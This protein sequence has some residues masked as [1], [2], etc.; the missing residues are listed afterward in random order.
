MAERFG[1]RFSPDNARPPEDG[2]APP[3]APGPLAGQRPR[4]AGARI[5]LLFLA[6]AV[7]LFTA[8][9]GTPV[10]LA[11]N[12]AAFAILTLATWLTR[13][14][15]AAE[16][17]YDARN[18]ARRPAFPRKIFGSVL[19]G[20]GLG[21][22]GYAAGQGLVNPAIFAVLGAGL[23]FM[24]FGPD[25][26]RD[27]GMSGIDRAEG[28]RVRRAVDEAEAHLAAMADAIRRAGDRKLEA[29]V[30]RFSAA[31]RA[32]FRRVEE[33]PRDL[34]ASR[35]YLGVY[36]MGARDATVKFADLYAQNRDAGARKDYEALL[37]DLEANFAGQSQK[38]LLN[39]RTAL[40]IEIEVLRE[41]LSREGVRAG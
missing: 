26:L 14:G 9:L 19:T 38:L 2:S 27:K 12:L 30:A 18:V 22:G 15:I 21:V 28:E 13:A 1:G 36:L 39:D 34:A 32:M 8:F 16:A 25:P 33:D 29:R 31:A 6:P 10:E 3:P 23:H 7:F 4:R 37:D 41:R 20:L 11:T 24:A 5:N 17:A 40:D 35:K